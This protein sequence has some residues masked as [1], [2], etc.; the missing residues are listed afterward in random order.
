MGK[1]IVSS[2]KRKTA[3]ARAT[4]KEGK[5]RIRINGVPLEVLPNELSK[6]KISEIFIIAGEEVRESID[7]RVNVRG[8]GFMGQ[9]EAIRT[10]IA[11][12]LI[13]YYD[14]LTMKE[15]FTVYDKTIVSG[16]P[17]RTEPK[18]FGGRSSRS[19]FQ[20]SYR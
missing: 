14:D 2:G 11:R 5:G 7:I 17:R 13:E 3:I 4:I 10:A 9:A 12:G 8:G 16:D 1:V 6:I 20:K 19:R 18:H 15:K